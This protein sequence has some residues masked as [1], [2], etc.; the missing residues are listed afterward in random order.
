M[1]IWA[2]EKNAEKMG[3]HWEIRGKRELPILVKAIG[4]DITE[5]M[6]LE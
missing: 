3:M 2:K 4:G 1:M 6:T 5:S